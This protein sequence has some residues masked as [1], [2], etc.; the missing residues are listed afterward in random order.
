[1][2]FRHGLAQPSS[3]C[4]SLQADNK[5]PAAVSHAVHLHA[6]TLSLSSNFFLI[7]PQL[8]LPIHFRGTQSIFFDFFLLAGSLSAVLPRHG[9]YSSHL[10]PGSPPIAQIPRIRPPLYLP[11]SHHLQLPVSA[12]PSPSRADPLHAA[13]LQIRVSMLPLRSGVGPACAS[14]RGS[15]AGEIKQGERKKNGKS[16][17]HGMILLVFSFLPVDGSCRWLPSQG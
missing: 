11:L 3:P 2:S 9:Y 14:S 10:L 4:T 17:P 13:E 7:Q 12:R 8:P 5:A 16:N 6:H 15:P 1:M